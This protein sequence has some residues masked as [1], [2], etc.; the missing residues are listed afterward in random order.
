L[1]AG[2]LS[3]VEGRRGVAM[4]HCLVADSLVIGRL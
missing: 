2:R 3:A 1:V 4:L